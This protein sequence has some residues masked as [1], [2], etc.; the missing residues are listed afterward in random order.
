MAFDA[1]IHGDMQP[2]WPL[3]SSNLLLGLI[4]VGAL[5]IVCLVLGFFGIVLLAFAATLRDDAT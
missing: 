2:F 1:V 5:H 4:G 3:T